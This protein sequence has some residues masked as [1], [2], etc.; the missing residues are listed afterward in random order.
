MLVLVLCVGIGKLHNHS[1]SVVV[2]LNPVAA[3]NVTGVYVFAPLLTI[4]CD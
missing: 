4:A 3:I 1:L 2:I